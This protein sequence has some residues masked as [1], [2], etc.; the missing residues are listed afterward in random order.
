M[1][2]LE[3]SNSKTFGEVQGTFQK[4]KGPEIDEST[5]TYCPECRRVLYSV[6]KYGPMTPHEHNRNF[7]VCGGAMTGEVKKRVTVYDVKDVDPN[8]KDEN[9]RSGSK[10]GKSRS[11]SS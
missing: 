3:T 1:E 8:Y 11:S 7:C 5:P 2:S 6:Y 10:K 9:D 4:A